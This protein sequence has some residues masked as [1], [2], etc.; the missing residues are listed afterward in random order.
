MVVA[1]R[2]AG[3]VGRMK[4]A[5]MAIA[6]EARLELEVRPAE[7]TQTKAAGLTLLP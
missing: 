6:Y 2:T 4:D 5:L 3:D 7:R 1:L